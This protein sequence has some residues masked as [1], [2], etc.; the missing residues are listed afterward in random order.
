MAQPDPTRLGEHCASEMRAIRLLREEIAQL[1]QLIA[2]RREC[3]VAAWFGI[4]PVRSEPE[5]S[6]F[7]T[8]SPLST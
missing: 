4:S 6:R 3:S 1:L 2:P 8:T 5:S 7:V